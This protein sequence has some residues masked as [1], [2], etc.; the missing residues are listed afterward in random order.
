M[1]RALFKKQF[2]EINALYFQDKKTG[3][4]RSK[5]GIVAFVLLFAFVF[6]SVGMAFFGTADMLTDALIPL[7]LDW[8]YFSLMGMMAIALGVFGSV[9]N[10]FAGLYHAKDN[11]LLLSMPIKPSQIL[12]VRMSS[13]YAMS[14]LYTSLVWVPTFLQYG[15]KTGWKAESIGFSIMLTFILSAFVT[16]LTCALGYVVALISGKLKNKSF[17]TVI[18]SVAFLGIYYFV[19][20][21]INSLLQSLVMYSNEIS[22]AIKRWVFPIYHLG[23]GASGNAI[24]LLIFTAITMALFAICILILSR[25]FIK[26]I[27][28]NTSSKKAVY[29]EKSTKASNQKTAL[30]KKELRR[31]VSS[32]TYML[33]N[34]LGILIMIVVAVAALIKANDINMILSVVAAE[35]NGFENM[36]P[37]IALSA[38][39]MFISTNVISAPSVSLEGKHIWIA[40]SLPVDTLQILHAKQKMHILIN[41][42]PTVICTALIGISFKI[43]VITTFFM[44]V[45]AFCFICFTS[46]LGLTL[47]LKKPNLEWTNEA[48][49]I[50]Q[51]MSVT[52]TLFSGWA[53][54][55]A[56][57]AVDYLLKVLNPIFYLVMVDVVLII[58]S[59]LL[60]KWIK[61]KGTKIFEEL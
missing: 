29:K 16:V 46:A 50:K 51:S 25:S 45:T 6:F 5:G 1:M 55:I 21:K 2:L 36:V 42:V 32:P 49:P 54:V 17:I 10:T 60:N 18:L 61:T 12:L 59:L 13:V 43:N 57:V 7:N 52:L 4:L 22:G 34:G 56:I 38:I 58:S 27:T 30:L 11:D 26:I 20:F 15:V 37:V 35:L 8:L 48:V 23:L 19:Y 44:V 3:K 39:L 33:N 41:T 31:F 40:Q 9:F 14:L 28:S 47:N 53:I 24:S